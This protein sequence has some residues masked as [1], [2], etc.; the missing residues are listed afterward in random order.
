[1]KI[2]PNDTIEWIKCLK[3]DGFEIFTIAI[4]FNLLKYNLNY[5]FEINWKKESS[6]ALYFDCLREIPNHHLINN[7]YNYS[8][9]NNLKIVNI[10]KINPKYLISYLNDYRYELIN[11]YNDNDDDNFYIEQL[12]AMKSTKYIFKFDAKLN[13]LAEIAD[14][15]NELNALIYQG[16]YN[17]LPVNNLIIDNINSYNFVSKMYYYDKIIDIKHWYKLTILWKI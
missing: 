9:I 10:S 13:I 1:M 15:E 8:F 2:I 7:I 3:S 17:K 16:K 5:H 14:S 11:V 12:L 6:S 4:L